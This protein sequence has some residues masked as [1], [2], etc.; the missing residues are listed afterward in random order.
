MKPKIAGEAIREPRGP[1]DLGV[2]RRINTKKRDNTKIK[3]VPQRVV[4]YP[5]VADKFK[6]LEILLYNL[7]YNLK[8]ELDECKKCFDLLCFLHN[9]IQHPHNRNDF[10]SKN[11]FADILHAIVT[12]IFMPIKAG[13]P[14]KSY[15]GEDEGNRVHFELPDIKEI[16]Y[17]IYELNI[18]SPVWLKDISAFYKLNSEEFPQYNFTGGKAKRKKETGYSTKKIPPSE[19]QIR[20]MIKKHLQVEKDP[21]KPTKPKTSDPYAIY[22]YNFLKALYK[23][24]KVKNRFFQ[25]LKYQFFEDLWDNKYAILNLRVSKYY[26]GEEYSEEE[27]ESTNWTI[28]LSPVGNDFLGKYSLF[29]DNPF[30]YVYRYRNKSE[31]NETA[32]TP[33]TSEYEGKVSS[34]D[35]ERNII[36]IKI[37]SKDFSDS[38]FKPFYG[39]ILRQDYTTF[40]REKQAILDFVDEN[41]NLSIKRLIIN[42]DFSNS[43]YDISIENFCNNNLNESQKTAVENAIKAEDFFCIHGP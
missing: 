35:E 19:S 39:I 36:S 26:P 2:I 17:H 23:E 10:V 13:E 38:K 30:V 1:H 41:K 15:T 42:K 8:Y 4:E 5:E 25:E 6:E 31:I 16:I 22:E 3:K 28:K 40:Q 34:I 27:E 18:L 9:Y 37:R 20:I 7:K 24:N 14:Y 43:F 12:E 33:A 11:K 32:F 21:D 29:K